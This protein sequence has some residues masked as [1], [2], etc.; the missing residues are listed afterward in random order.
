MSLSQ[1]KLFFLLLMFL[2]ACGLEACG[3]KG[4]PI[5]PHGQ[6]DLYPVLYPPPEHDPEEQG[7]ALPLKISPK[8]LEGGDQRGPAHSTN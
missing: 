7:R 8:G 1:K 4:A 2:G 3:K 5:P 6:E